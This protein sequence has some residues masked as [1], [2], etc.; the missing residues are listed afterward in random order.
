MDDRYSRE[1]H[2][3]RR[4]KRFLA[5]FNTKKIYQNKLYPR[6]NK[7]RKKKDGR[8]GGRE[9]ERALGL[10]SIAAKTKKSCRL[11]RHLTYKSHSRSPPKKSLSHRT[12]KRANSI[13]EKRKKKL[14][15]YINTH[16]ML[17]YSFFYKY[18][19]DVWPFIVP[20]GKSQYIVVAVVIEERGGASRFGLLTSLS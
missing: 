8:D 2:H 18:T 19:I 6:E 17:T 11:S 4:R 7:E 10:H 3:S 12:V 16:K 20:S 15:K 14:F 1:R 5:V 13:L 9:R